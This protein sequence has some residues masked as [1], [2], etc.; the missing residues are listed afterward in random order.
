MAPQMAFLGIGLMGQVRPWC[1]TRKDSLDVTLSN[2]REGHD[3]EHSR[4]SEPR[5]PFDSME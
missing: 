3:E 2:R 4:Q 5:K 1:P